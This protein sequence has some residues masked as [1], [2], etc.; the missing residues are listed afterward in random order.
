MPKSKKER[1][2]STPGRLKG[3]NCQRSQLKNLYCLDTKLWRKNPD[4]WSKC[5][6]EVDGQKGN[7]ITNN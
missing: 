7:R 6:A 4:L 5:C 3:S 2:S 1:P